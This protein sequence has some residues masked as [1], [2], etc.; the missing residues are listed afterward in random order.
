[1]PGAETTRTQSLI[2]RYYEEERELKQKELSLAEQAVHLDAND[3][4]LLS[5]IA[6]RFHKSRGEVAQEILSNALLDLFARIDG[7]ERK[8][9]ARDADETAK[10]MAE[11]IAEE[12]NLND[13]DFKSGFWALQD[14]QITKL[15]KQ[16]AKAQSNQVQKSA[17]SELPKAA[18][19]APETEPEQTE[20]SEATSVFSES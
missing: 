2:D 6:Q 3:L 5:T 13:I 4:A 20:E 12:N 16:Q 19:V 14:R 10:N 8:L 1:M 9:L 18:S 7:G 15:E 17:N 11:S